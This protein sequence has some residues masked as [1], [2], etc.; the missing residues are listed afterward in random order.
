[1]VVV[2]V[3]TLGGCA[4]TTP[5]SP[6]ATPRAAG[7]PA[8]VALEDLN[9][10]I[11]DTAVISGD[12]SFGLGEYRLN[13][14]GEALLSNLSAKI[15]SSDGEIAISGYADGVGGFSQANVDIS[16]KRADAVADWLRGKYPELSN[17]VIRCVGYGADG[18]VSGVLAVD[19]VP[20]P[21]RR[22]VVITIR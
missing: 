14:E 7:S 18:S 15:L 22:V 19:G 11:G 16:Q 1:M 2:L 21:L 17:R 20:D 12:L 6:T 8:P 9:R 5:A 10:W 4:A 13:P 3:A